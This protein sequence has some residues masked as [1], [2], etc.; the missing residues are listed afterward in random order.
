MAVV[1]LSVVPASSFASFL[2][3]AQDSKQI[4]K[5]SGKIVKEVFANRNMTLLNN[6]NPFDRSFRLRT[7]ADGVFL[8]SYGDNEKNPFVDAKLAL[9]F[10]YD[11]GAPALI[12]TTTS[13]LT[14]AD[15]AVELPAANIQKSLLWLREL[16]IRVSL[17]RNEDASTH[18]VK[19]GSFPYE[20]GRGIALGAA[21]NSGG[22]LGLDPRFAID[23]FAPGGL[24]HTDIFD[25]SLSGELYF[26]ILN[27]P[28]SSYKENIE[29]IRLNEITEISSN[30]YRGLNR[31]S[32]F[33][34]GA[35]KWKALNFEDTKLTV[36]PYAY[37]YVSPDQKL[38][39]PADSNSQLYAIGAAVEFKHNKFEWGFESAFQG[40]TTLVKA[41]DRN[42]QTIKNDD[43]TVTVVYTKVYSDAD[44]KIPAVVTT[45]NKE[46]VAS[47]PKGYQQNGQ[48]IGT[49]GLY[50]G[51]D[52]FRPEQ[53]ILYHGFFWVT[54]MSYDVIDDQ[55]KLCADVGYTSGH[56]DA[57]NNVNNMTQADLNKQKFNGFIPV[58]SIYSGK[59]IQHL[60]ML[61]TGVPRFTVEN[62]YISAKDQNVQSRVMG[63][64]TLT[65]KFTNLAYTAF[66]IECSPA[67]FKD[68][69][70]LI[71]PV[72]IYYWMPDAPMLQDGK[73]VASHAL[74]AALSI[75]FEATIKEC[76]EMGGYVGWMIPGP[77]Y[78]QFAGLKL[79]DGVLGSDVAYVLNF[80]MTYKF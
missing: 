9:R 44:L 34:S 25:G 36:D 66:A 10:R 21:Y 23:Q 20:L 48:P 33:F 56:L 72:A 12:S 59:R 2:G 79:K 73:T 30:N 1:L 77:Q 54:D 51:I 80:T 24:L 47:G 67:R 41:W 28:N 35:L 16:F 60:V 46:A 19:F 43:G 62:P 40:G 42:Y 55:L 6:A 45:A 64:K 49:S 78:K 58:Q 50:N 8:G 4:F 26:S 3:T 63:T 7:T 75:E 31:Q 32:W 39:F 14:L 13:S 11:A 65:D 37:G 5:T 17:D 70:G 29:V 22:F 57:F 53:N 38:D 15:A 74:G 69:D 68:Q 27:N 52:R 61:N 76:L 71:K 18:F